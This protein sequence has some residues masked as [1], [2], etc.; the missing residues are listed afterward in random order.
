MVNLAANVVGPWSDLTHCPPPDDLD[1]PS[2]YSCYR[3]G[4]G[5]GI[6]P[7]F[8]GPAYAFAAHT[9]IGIHRRNLTGVHHRPEAQGSVD[10]VS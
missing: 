8:Y 1:L 6:P 9:L 5:A 7:F 2:G 10:V 4:T 3:N